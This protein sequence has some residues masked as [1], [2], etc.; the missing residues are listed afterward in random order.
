MYVPEILCFDN[1]IYREYLLITFGFV[2]EYGKKIQLF[3]FPH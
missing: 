3:S 2:Q 1:L